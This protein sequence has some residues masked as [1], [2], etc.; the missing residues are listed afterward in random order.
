MNIGSNDN[1]SRAKPSKVFIEALSSFGPP[2]KKCI[3]F[4]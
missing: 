4:D 1:D 2:V 3:A